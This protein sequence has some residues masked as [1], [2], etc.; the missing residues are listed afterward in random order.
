MSETGTFERLNR[1]F[2]SACPSVYFR[3]RLQML[4]LRAA[5]P[6]LIDDNITEKTAWGALR[7]AARSAVEPADATAESE[8]AHS[9]FLVTESQVLLHHAAEA[10]LRMFLAHEAQP[11][12][13]WLEIAAFKNNS[14]FRDEL[15]VL[16]EGTWP[17]DRKNLTGWV[18][19]GDVPDD[20]PAEWIAHRDAAV[21]LIRILAQTVNGDSELY[22]GVKHGFTALGGMGSIHFL[23]AD[24]DQPPPEFT[25]DLLET[26]AVLGADGV[27]VAYLERE[28]TRKHGIWY[29]K[30]QW[31]NPEK[32]AYL[33]QLA[34]IQMEALWA[35]SRSRYLGEAPPE[36]GVHLVAGEGLDRLRDFPRGGSVQSWRWK[37]ATETL[38]QS[39][40][41]GAK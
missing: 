41:L 39:D 36:G 8:A 28:G 4:V 23:P 25:V 34:I 18:F 27:N 22:N 19:L 13:P 17:E 30:T 38:G 14:K 24:T 10:F 29:H 3:D 16:S 40:D 5:N 35:I 9:R 20:P 1:E 32:S 33:A 2:Y 15:D 12:C 21:R 37:V 31:V 11:E 7:F 6:K 26:E